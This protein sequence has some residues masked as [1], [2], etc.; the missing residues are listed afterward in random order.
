MF[1][2][3]KLR[4]KSLYGECF[5]LQKLNINFSF[6]FNLEHLNRLE[7]TYIPIHMYTYYNISNFNFE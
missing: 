7:Q 5:I 3:L 6:Y 4:L 1:Q 2:N